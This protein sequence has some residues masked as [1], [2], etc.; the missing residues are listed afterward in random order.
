MARTMKRW[1]AA[2]A[3]LLG[4]SALAAGCQDGPPLDDYVHRVFDLQCKR[5]FSCC[6]ATE[7]ERLG[8]FATEEACRADREGFEQ[9]AVS[10][11][12]A[13]LDAD[14]TAVDEGALASCLTTIEASSCSAYFERRDRNCE[15][16]FAP[17]VENGGDCSSNLT[18]RGGLCRSF[19]CVGDTR[20]LGAACASSDDCLSS[21][22][23]AGACAE[24]PSVAACSGASASK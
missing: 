4:I 23:L 1:T 11:I 3:V 7:R 9:L 6:T 24:S 20:P 19:V 8:G 2:A 12:R 22:C 13:D 15:G 18:C 5:I 17:K 10:S 16:A 14:L 21:N